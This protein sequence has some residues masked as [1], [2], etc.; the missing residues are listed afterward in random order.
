MDKQA[1]M[2]SISFILPKTTAILPNLR[3]SKL[4]VEGEFPGTSESVVRMTGFSLAHCALAYFLRTGEIS[5][6]VDLVEC[7]VHAT[8]A[9]VSEVGPGTSHAWSGLLEGA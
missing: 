6:Q 9:G 7:E 2:I 8:G 3:N 5:L 4:V 1:A